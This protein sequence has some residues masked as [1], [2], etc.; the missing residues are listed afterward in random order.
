MNDESG[1]DPGYMPSETQMERYP[2]RPPSIINTSLARAPPILAGFLRDV[3][4]GSVADTEDDS[5]NC[6]DV[7]VE[8][9]NRFVH[10]TAPLSWLRGGRAELIRQR[11]QEL[12]SPQSP[13]RRR[14]A[15]NSER[16]YTQREAAEYRIS[17]DSTGPCTPRMPESVALRTPPLTPESPWRA[18][19]SIAAVDDIITTPSKASEHQHVVD[20]EGSLSSIDRPNKIVE[21]WHIERNAP[22]Q[23]LVGVLR[24][25]ERADSSFALV[26]GDFW[27]RQDD[28]KQFPYDPPLSDNGR[29][30]ARKI[31]ET[32]QKLATHCQTGMHSVV[33]SPFLRCIQTAV[34]VCVVLGPSSRLLVDCTLGEVYGPSVMGQ[35]KPSL[36]GI[37]RNMESVLAICKKRGVTCEPQLVGHW[38]K[39]PEHLP[40]ARRRFAKRFLTYLRR[41][42]R[43]RRNFLIVTH[44][45]GVGAA[46]SMMPSEVGSVL[47]KVEFGGMFLA[48]RVLDTGEDMLSRIGSKVS[49]VSG[50]SLKSI[51]SGQGKARK[52]DDN[53]DDDAHTASCSSKDSKHS[54]SGADK[55]SSKDSKHSD[56]EILEKTTEDRDKG[57]PESKELGKKG[58]F[59]CTDGPDIVRP[60]SGTDGWRVQHHGITQ[61]E[62]KNNPAASLDFRL[63]GVVD[64]DRF[65]RQL[66][67]QLL[68]ESL[69]EMPL[70]KDDSIASSA[71]EIAMERKKLLGLRLC[72]SG[73]VSLSTL[74][75]G[76]ATHDDLTKLA[77]TPGP[78]TSSASLDLPPTEPAPE[79][80]PT[81]P[82]RD[83]TS[84]QNITMDLSMSNS[85]MARNRKKKEERK[86]TFESNERIKEQLGQAPLAEEPARAEPSLP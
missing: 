61:A 80:S 68:V 21:K 37:V 46:L 32:V 25:T 13:E 9:A 30:H 81:V 86:Q 82:A 58:V 36:D 5:E 10:S 45:D 26:D 56:E 11:S 38:P 1:L 29:E 78:Y 55:C 72:S 4:A 70:G 19:P 3:Q 43:V 75:F 8:E 39:W 62:S 77:S 34:E 60:P 74:L 47:E 33:S 16:S 73:S 40:A 28:S 51:S 84:K 7:A 27:H 64:N 20:I 18:P 35:T 85:M 71:D 41:G 23:Q 83:A 63:K 15:G 57:R 76:G 14:L 48:Q 42:V 6:L 66:I 79:G 24:H 52:S 54:K 69:S 53:R 31:G 44:A 67:E 65:S 50:E 2:T 59:E 17:P 49:K 22:T 12:R